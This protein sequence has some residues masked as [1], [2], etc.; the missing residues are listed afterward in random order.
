MKDEQS[1][2]PSVTAGSR[3]CNALR[4]QGVGSVFCLSGAAHA[5]LLRDMDNANFSIISTRTEAGTVAAADGYARTSG[6]IGVAMVV[7]KQGL[8]NTIGGLR[9]AQLACSPVL[10]LAHVYEPRSQE[11]MDEG[12]DDQLAM[13]RPYAKWA[14]IVPSPERLEE[15]VNAAIH[16]ATSGR[17]GVAVLGI[18]VHFPKAMVTP[19]PQI[20]T[21]KTFIAPPQPDAEAIA[22]ACELIRGAKRPLL[23]VGSGAALADAGPELKALADMGLPVFGHAL[24]RGLVAEDND[25]AF[26]FSLAQVAAK[27]A[28]VVVSLGMRFSQRIGF[29]LAPRFAADAKFVQVDIEPGELGRTR[30]IDIPICADAKAVAGA[31]QQA[32][33]NEGFKAPSRQW[34]GE[35]IAARDEI[36]TELAQ[37]RNG[38][39][40]PLQIGRRLMDRLPENAI[41]VVDGADIYNWMSGILKVRSPRSYMDHYPLGSMGI[42]TGLALGAA[43]ASKEQAEQDGSAPRPVILVTGDGSFGYY[44][45]ELN[46]A[47][48]ASLPLKCVISNDGAW[49]TEKNSHLMHWDNAIN[50]ELGQCDYQLIAEAYGCTNAK[51]DKLSALDTALDAMMADNAP[52]VLNALTDP[53]AGLARKQD[54]RL[55]MVTFEDLP[56]NQDAHNVQDLA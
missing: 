13:V 37:D 34:I 12:P 3:V 2:P 36:I 17:P 54:K 30:Q 14:K 33:A 43:A 35:G 29:G 25:H 26:A 11:S 5:H 16:R 19:K 21:P 20:D 24:G 7:G 41:I 50:C 4:A 6:N 23:L 32:L 46:S 47:S 42:C 15:Y 22:Q 40:H 48:L 28:D 56:A 31:L 38:P 53:D 8:P 27:H 1:N 51:V 9:T 55:Q 44:T 18:P 45:A 49:G 39:I 52:F 10:I